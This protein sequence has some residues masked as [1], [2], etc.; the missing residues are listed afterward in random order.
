MTQS[1]WMKGV[2]YGEEGSGFYFI[3][4]LAVEQ[5]VLNLLSLTTR[6]M[7]LNGI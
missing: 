1:G 6:L 4:Y 7:I 5:I 2:G 3:I